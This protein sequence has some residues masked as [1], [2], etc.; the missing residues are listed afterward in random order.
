MARPK[1]NGPYTPLAANYFLDDSILEA[2]E[3][4]ELLFV[5]CLSFLADWRFGRVH[6]GSADASRGRRQPPQRREAHRH[7]AGCWLVAA[8]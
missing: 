5:R 1:S 2:K 4:A 6:L 7:V 8:S 3:H